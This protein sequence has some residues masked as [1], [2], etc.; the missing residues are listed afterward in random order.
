MT[1]EPEGKLRDSDPIL[2]G[3]AMVEER[4]RCAGNFSKLWKAVKDEF[5]KEGEWLILPEVFRQLKERREFSKLQSE[6]GK[7]GA[8]ARKRREKSNAS[9]ISWNGKEW[10]PSELEK[11]LE[12]ANSEI[13]RL[14]QG[15]LNA[16]SAELRASGQAEIETLKGQ[17]DSMKRALLLPDHPI[18]HNKYSVTKNGPS[19]LSPAK[20][21]G[22]PDASMERTDLDQIPVSQFS[23]SSLDNALKA[24][25]EEI[26]EIKN[27]SAVRNLFYD[28]DQLR[29]QF[30]DRL[31]HLEERER[32]LIGEKF[33]REQLKE[34]GADDLKKK[35]QKTR[36]SSTTSARPK[37]KRNIT[38]TPA[39]ASSPAGSPPSS[40]VALQPASG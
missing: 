23:D 27:P 32:E 12:R 30:A 4:H 38:T 24:V 39:T 28:G 36:K 33:Q 7:K 3:L 6:R 13:R 8:E 5:R 22:A 16:K 1:N 2:I 40:T 15:V 25:V 20:I 11:N 9:K 37:R 19:P 29:P 14:A 18:E 31:T 21:S 10:F 35:S 17:R 34:C 26:G